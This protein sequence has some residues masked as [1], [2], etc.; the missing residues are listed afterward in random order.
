MLLLMRVNH[1][2][3]ALSL[4][5]CWLKYRA[6]PFLV[7]GRLHF[8]HPSSAP[9]FRSATRRADEAPRGCGPKVLA[10]VRSDVFDIAAPT[11]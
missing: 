2:V 4:L 7:N 9:E 1:A 3:L 10:K 5:D 8:R 6:W 11:S